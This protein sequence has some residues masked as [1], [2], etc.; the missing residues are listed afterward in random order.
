MGRE[1]AN[2]PHVTLGAVN[3]KQATLDYDVV[4]EHVSE[5]PQVSDLDQAFVSKVPPTVLAQEHKRL[6]DFTATLEKL[7]QQLVRLG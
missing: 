1:V 4:F 2:S 5:L 6:A 3:P 7:Q